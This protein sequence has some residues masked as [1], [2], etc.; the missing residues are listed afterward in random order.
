MFS[1]CVIAVLKF[2]LPSRRWSLAPW[3]GVVAC[4]RGVH[5][6]RG[7]VFIWCVDGTSQ[8]Y[9]PRCGRP[10]DYHWLT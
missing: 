7:V 10:F 6:R 3:R 9:C 8:A 5:V 2:L 4:W 1:R